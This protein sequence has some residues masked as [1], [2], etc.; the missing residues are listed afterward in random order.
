[1]GATWTPI[2]YGQTP[3]DH[4]RNDIP[5]D[6]VVADGTGPG[7]RD[8][9]RVYYAAVRED[10]G[11]VA[12]VTA[13]AKQDGGVVYKNF[14]E[15]SLPYFFTAPDNV[16]AALSPTDNE[17]AQEW[18]AKVRE[19]AAKNYGPSRLRDGMRVTFDARWSVGNEFV[20][21]KRGRT[22]EFEHPVSGS[23]YRLRGWTKVAWAEV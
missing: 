22:W 9:P 18:R 5:R 10:D 17:C 2:R 14:T 1:M 20:A 13:Y 7:D 11:V 3:L 16:M 6:R 21:R 15:R 12:Y 4:V 8:W 23:V 19:Q